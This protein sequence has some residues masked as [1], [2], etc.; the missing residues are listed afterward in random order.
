MEFILRKANKEDMKD[1]FNL[2]NEEIVRQNSINKEQIKWENHVKWFNDKL[3]DENH[4]FF[5]ISNDENDFLGQVR[6]EIKDDG[7]IIS[8]SVSEKIRGKGLSSK[9][10]EIACENAFRERRDICKI[11]AYISPKNLPSIK[12]FER[13]AFIFSKEDVLKGNVFNLYILKSK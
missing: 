2:S 8:V 4:L 13:S 7:T 11:L 3:A 12:C 9:I 1:V 5:V 6:F 10:V